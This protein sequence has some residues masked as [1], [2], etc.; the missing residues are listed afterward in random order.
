MAKI[1]FNFTDFPDKLIYNDHIE[2]KIL[3]KNGDDL[4]LP[5]YLSI[6]NNGITNKKDVLVLRVFNWTPEPQNFFVGLQLY[7]GLFVPSLEDLSDRVKIE[8]MQS[9]RQTRG[10]DFTHAAVIGEV[11]LEGITMPYNSPDWGND[12]DLWIDFVSKGPNINPTTKGLDKDQFDLTYWQSR[13]INAVVMPWIP[14]FTNCNG[15]DS[16]II[17]YDLFEYANQDQCDLPKYEE[18]QIVSPIPSNGLDATADR[19]TI[20]MECRF[21]EDMTFTRSQTIRWYLIQEPTRMFYV[22][23]EPVGID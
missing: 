1:Y 15:H 4:P 11:L 10:T 3:D 23:R 8:I 17:F 2:I 18:L 9:E 16:H 22:T 19:C 21:D 7:H 5:N 12:P 20:S 6:N 14:Y 13:K